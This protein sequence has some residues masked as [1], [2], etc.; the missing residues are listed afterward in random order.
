MLY[1]Y[2]DIAHIEAEIAL[3][4]NRNL[5]PVDQSSIVQLGHNMHKQAAAGTNSLSIAK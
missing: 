1:W 3:L 2:D 4:D 5:L